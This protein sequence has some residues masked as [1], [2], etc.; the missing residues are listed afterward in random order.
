[1][2]DTDCISAYFGRRSFKNIYLHLMFSSVLNRDTKASFARMTPFVLTFFSNLNMTVGSINLSIHGSTCQYTVQLVNTR[3]NLS[4]QGLKL[5]SYSWRTPFQERK[6]QRFNCSNL[7]N[8]PNDS[9]L[10]WKKKNK[11][12]FS[13]IE[14]VFEKV[15]S[16][17]KNSFGEEE[18]Q[19]FTDQKFFFFCV[20][21]LLPKK[22]RFKF[23][24]T[25]DL[26]MCICCW[27]EKKPV[28]K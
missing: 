13:N 15:L 26:K 27:H 20:Q 7:Y 16:R 4:I 12:N 22:T 24:I 3:F 18:F 6:R 9:L 8:T 17:A 14:K 21:N 10:M 11:S 28:Q 1:M 5:T 23:S 19:I 25:W 2:K